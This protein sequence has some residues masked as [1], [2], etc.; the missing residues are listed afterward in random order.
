MQLPSYAGLTGDVTSEFT[1]HLGAVPDKLG[2]GEEFKE[3]F[4]F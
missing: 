4:F 1:V 2:S 3:A